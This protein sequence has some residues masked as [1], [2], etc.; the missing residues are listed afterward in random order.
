MW[1]PVLPTNRARLCKQILGES[2]DV[3]MLHQKAE[4]LTGLKSLE[5][6]VPCKILILK[7]SP[8]LVPVGGRCKDSK[9]HQCSADLSWTDPKKLLRRRGQELGIFRKSL[10]RVLKS[11]L[12]LYQVKQKLAEADMAKR[13]TMC[14]WC[15]DTIEDNP[16]FLDHV[17]FSDEAYFLLSGHVNSK[18]NVY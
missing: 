8:T 5:S 4:F 13:V 6:I 16:D 12:H 18:N 9:K 10:R 17:W 2:F 7:A 3:K 11:D 1:W 15:C 14:K